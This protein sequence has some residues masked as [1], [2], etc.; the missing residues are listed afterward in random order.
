MPKEA[1]DYKNTVIYMIR[2]NISPHHPFH[3][4]YTTNLTKRKYLHRNDVKNGKTNL[5]IYAVIKNTGGWD[6]WRVV[7]IEKFP[8]TGI[9]EIQKRIDELQNFYSKTVPNFDT[10]E[11]KNDIIM[12]NQ[13]DIIISS[14]DDSTINEIMT[15][16]SMIQ[17]GIKMVQK[18]YKNGMCECG[19]KYKHS[20]GYYR[21]KN[22]CTFIAEKSALLSSKNII[23]EDENNK[24][25]QNKQVQIDK[26]TDAIMEVVNKN[27]ELTKQLVIMSQTATTNNINHSFNKTFNLQVFLNEDCKHAINMKDFIESIQIQLSDLENTGNVGYVEGI[28]QIFMNNLEQLDT[29]ERPI[30]CTDVKR[31]TL[32]IKNDDIW[33]KEDEHK[34][35]LVH[36]IKQVTNKNIKLIKSWQEKHPEYK[37]PESKTNDRYIQIVF[38]AMSGSTEEEQVT[39]INKIARNIAKGVTIKKM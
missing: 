6:N 28:S 5:E 19:K 21:H 12:K 4:G 3:I 22:K 23:Q 11:E 17:N 39:N 24:Q 13:N 32:Y 36:A 18:W 34:S 31:E 14:N 37:D 15:E 7:E 26:L 8:C 1:I 30:H 9:Y 10:I 2:S 29:H 20:S 35:N 38:N 16:L 25:V 33:T 27:T